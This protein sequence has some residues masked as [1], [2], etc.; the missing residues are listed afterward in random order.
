M[1]YAR[2]QGWSVNNS[3][4]T[5][6]VQQGDSKSA[7]W[8]KAPGGALPG[9]G[10][11]EKSLRQHIT[12]GCKTLAGK[13]GPRFQMG[14]TPRWQ[15]TNRPKVKKFMRLPHPDHQN[16]L[17]HSGGDSWSTGRPFTPAACRSSMCPLAETVRLRDVTFV[18][19]LNSSFK[20]KVSTLTDVTYIMVFIPTLYW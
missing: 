12:A 16:Q 17:E 5:A 3:K 20:C 14:D 1:L 10:C 6:Q 13:H 9:A 8:Q 4:P 15:R 7:E 18:K 11:E 2:T 19:Q